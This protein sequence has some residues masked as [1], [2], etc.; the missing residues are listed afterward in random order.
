MNGRMED[1]G[2]VHRF[3]LA[4]A[5]AAATLS[6]LTT[7]QAV[8]AAPSP[9]A[10]FYTWQAPGDAWTAGQRVIALTFDDGPGPFTPQVL[11]VLEQYHV[12]ATFFEI[13]E[14]VADYPQYSKMVA[15]AGYPVED[16]TWTHPDL[17][18]LTASQV[19]YQIDETQ[20][21][22]RSVTGATPNCMRPPYDAWNATVLSADAARGITTMSYSVD[23]RD[24]SMPGVTAI[25]NV[26][27]GAAF[28]GAVVDMHDGGGTRSE[29]VAALP[30]IITDLRSEGY[31][32]V[33]ICG[34][35][36]PPPPPQ[37]SAV[38]AFGHAPSPAT[39]ITSNAPYVGAAGTPKGY[40]LVAQDGGVF[41]T[42]VPFYGSMGG[43]TLSRPVVGM[44]D[45]EDGTGYWL[46]AADGG[47]FSFG[48]ARFSGSMGGR[49]LNQPIVGMA[50]DPATGG[51]W[52]V[53]RDGGV[54][55][56]HAPFYGSM[57]GHHLNQPI[58]GMAA[59]ATGRGYWLVASD[60][61]IF[62]FGTAVFHGSMGGSELNQPIV[63]MAADPATGGYWEVARDGGVF[64]F[65]APFYGSV[66]GRA[67]GNQFFAM[68][69]APGGS[70]Y[71]LAGQHPAAS[72]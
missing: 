11:S 65:H 36:T 20:P 55:S 5:V 28:P 70:G 49:H 69:A 32:F 22:I 13:G 9:Q 34:N 7:A 14:N 4:A 35:A 48:D 18:T 23:P 39:P 29:T 19:A 46:V 25:V 58:V 47:I 59:A 2:L 33:S 62:S 30:R 63:G 31:G 42:G 26:V 61:G 60:G 51:Y 10:A 24:W 45:T 66:G 68:I 64:S 43:K 44:T 38:Y 15:A 56:F 8:G 6:G 21:E 27:V 50:A 37:I 71:L 72:S 1:A 54:F 16:H 67:T 3:L 52:E 57:G 12:P 40:W 17:A 53:A 41:S